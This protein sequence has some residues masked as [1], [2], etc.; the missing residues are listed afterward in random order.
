MTCG[1]V[2]K[3]QETIPA[4]GHTAVT[5]AGVKATCETAGKTEGSHCAACGKV[6]KA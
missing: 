2:L 1:K 5:D 6:L 4:K 3:A